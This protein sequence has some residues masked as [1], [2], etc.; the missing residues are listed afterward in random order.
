VTA[1]GRHGARQDYGVG[2]E[3]GKAGRWA[4]AQAWGIASAP[5]STYIASQEEF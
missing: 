2:R 1:R 3:G 5:R 4:G